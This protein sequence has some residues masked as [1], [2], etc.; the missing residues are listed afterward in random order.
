MNL[1]HPRQVAPPLADFT[2]LPWNDGKQDLNFDQPYLGNGVIHQPFANQQLLL[3]KGLHLHF[4][5]PQFLGR[6]APVFDSQGAAQQM[7]TAP[8]GK[9]P[10]APNRWLVIKTVN[11]VETGRWLVESDFVYNA[12]E[13]PEGPACIIPSQEGQPWR[14][15]GKTTDLKNPPKVSPSG[16]S[17][18]QL[19]HN[20]PITVSGSL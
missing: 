5:L 2:R 4:I 11:E 19:H 20:E 7:K 8:E 16:K 10:A 17:F 6:P 13:K 9:L 15:M 12:G 3:D 14:Y 18:S 1:D